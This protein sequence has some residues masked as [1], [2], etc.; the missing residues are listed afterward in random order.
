M[1]SICKDSLTVTCGKVVTGIG[2]DDRTTTI[3]SCCNVHDLS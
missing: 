1:E 2:H 3:F